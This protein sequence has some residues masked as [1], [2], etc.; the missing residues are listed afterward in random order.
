M[1]KR[2]KLTTVWVNDQAAAYD[3]YVNK[4]G[5]EVKSDI[6]MPDGYRWLEVKPVGAETTLGITKAGGDEN[7]KAGLFTNIIL[8]TDDI[9]ATYEDLKAKGVE[10]VDV[11]SKQPWGWWATLKDLDGNIF[12]VGQIEE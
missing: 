4:L 1:I 3:F 2:V 7:G 10:F 8:D 9:V 5:F 12:G 11:P 6:T